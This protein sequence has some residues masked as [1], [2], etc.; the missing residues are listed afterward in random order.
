MNDFQEQ[1]A[2]SR[3]EYENRSVDRFSRQVTF[4]CFVYGDSIYVRV[5]DEPE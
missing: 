3:I 2:S 4:E 1:L 5:V